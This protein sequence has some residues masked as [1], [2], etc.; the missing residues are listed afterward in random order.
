TIGRGQ[1]AGAFLRSYPEARAQ[2]HEFDVYA[3]EQ[4]RTA[5]HDSLAPPRQVEGAASGFEVVCAADFPDAEFELAALP[6]DPRGEAELTS[7]MLQ[8]AHCRLSIGGRLL[9]A[10]SNPEDQWLHGELRKLFPK[11]TRRPSDDGVLYLATK[12]EPLK[13]LKG[14]ECA[15]AFR[16]RGRLIQAV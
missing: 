10:T 13:K 2:L 6:V 14:H 4:V 1:F 3:A 11:V 16:D 5:V 9:A 15:L 7:E 12:N 8:Q